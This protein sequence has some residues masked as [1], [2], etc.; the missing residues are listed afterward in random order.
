MLDE[1]Y[2][3]LYGAYLVF[4]DRRKVIASTALFRC[5]CLDSGLDQTL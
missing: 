3:Q 5:L 4:R 1:Y 2:L